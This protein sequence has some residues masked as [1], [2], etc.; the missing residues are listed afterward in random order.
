MLKINDHF[1][2]VSSGDGTTGNVSSAST[3]K[4]RNLAHLLQQLDELGQPI[5]STNSG[6]DAMDGDRHLYGASAS[7]GSHLGGS[8]SGR[9]I[10][11]AEQRGERSRGSGSGGGGVCPRHS[12]APTLSL[13]SQMVEQDLAYLLAGTGVTGGS[14][15]QAFRSRPSRSSITSASRL[16]GMPPQSLS[17]VQRFV[18][19]Y[20]I[21]NVLNIH[22]LFL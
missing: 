14:E 4:I 22:F 19:I 8:S 21:K 12:M 6:D 20:F 16:L 13:D 18:L 7:G 17:A 9:S 11:S 10:T 3:I 2:S 1:Q 5:S 15:A